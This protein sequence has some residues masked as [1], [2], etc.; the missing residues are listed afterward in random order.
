MGPLHKLLGSLYLSFLRFCGF[1]LF[2]S[3]SFSISITRLRNIGQSKDHGPDL[4][5]NTTSYRISIFK[6][7]VFR[8]NKV[9]TSTI[10]RH[11]IQLY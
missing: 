2:Y 10:K 7:K 9:L 11:I 6:T 4:G 5:S 1:L 3:M 8:R